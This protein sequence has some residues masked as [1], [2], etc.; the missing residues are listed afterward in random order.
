MPPGGEAKPQDGSSKNLV[1]RF[2]QDLN[3]NLFIYLFSLNYFIIAQNLAKI[4][5]GN[6]L[7]VST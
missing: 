7:Q 4:S 5:Y 6:E 2:M 3:L 1:G